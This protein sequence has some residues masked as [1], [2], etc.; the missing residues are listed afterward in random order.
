MLLAGIEMVTERG[1]CRPQSPDELEMTEERAQ[2]RLRL[3]RD[4]YWRAKIHNL[5][6]KDRILL[7][8]WNFTIGRA[9]W[10]NALVLPVMSLIVYSQWDRLSKFLLTSSFP[11]FG[12]SLLVLLD[13]RICRYV[14]L[15]AS[16]VWGR[17]EVG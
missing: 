17:L 13:L 9:V 8:V 16:F 10:V 3:V 6:L 4:F 7:I 14:Y 12:L 15:T 5:S 1:S 2:A 11:S